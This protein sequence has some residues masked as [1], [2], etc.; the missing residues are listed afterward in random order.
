ME[1]GSGGFLADLYFIGGKFGLVI[2]KFESP[3]C[4]IH[5]NIWWQC[6]FW[7]P[8]IHRQWSLVPEC[9]DRPSDLLGLGL[10]N[11]KHCC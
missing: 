3:S 6:I 4:L 1:N 7:K 10:D 5:S 11:A 9:S 2:T 8:A